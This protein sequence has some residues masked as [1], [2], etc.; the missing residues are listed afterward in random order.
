M[1]KEK[2]K[3]INLLMLGVGTI[4]TSMVV[5][6]LILGFIVDWWLETTPI[7]MMLFLLLGFVG[8]MLKVYKMLTH[9]EMF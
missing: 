9:P 6:G 4:L 3:K 1:V 7:F 5:S 2:E 8:G